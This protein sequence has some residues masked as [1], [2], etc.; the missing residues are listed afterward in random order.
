MLRHR[1][2]ELQRVVLFAARGA[3]QVVHARHGLEIPKSPGVTR[4]TQEAERAVAEGDQ[5]QEK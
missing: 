3:T 5:D 4:T 2:S 1:T